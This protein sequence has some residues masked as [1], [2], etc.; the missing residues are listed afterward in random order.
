MPASWP[1][2]ATI[3]SKKAE[4]LTA[5]TNAGFSLPAGDPFTTALV[6]GDDWDQVLD[7]IQ[8]AIDDDPSIA[9]YSAL[10]NLVKDGNLN[11]FPDAPEEEEPVDPEL[12]ANLDV[13]TDY[14]GTYTVIGS[15]EGDPG[16]CAS[17]GTATRDHERGTVTISPQGDI[18]FD[19]GISFTVD[20]IVEIYDRKTVDADRRVAVNYGQSDSD[21]RV[22]LYLNTDLEVMEIIHDD[23]AGATTRA[24]IQE[25]STDPE[26]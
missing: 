16:Y 23:G 18:D 25:E 2:A 14:A 20:D 19:I 4:L 13:L 6:I 8:E 3:E 15:G 24:L 21:E 22:R 10:L 1:E 11:Q 26:P 12:P 5:M 9:D 7:A 17:C